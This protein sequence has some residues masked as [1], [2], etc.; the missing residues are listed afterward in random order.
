MPGKP[1]GVVAAP[2]DGGTTVSWT[3]PASDGGADITGYTVA[4][5]RGGG[6]CTTSGATTCTVTGLTNGV[7]YD[8]RVQ[9]T[10]SVGTGKGSK[11]VNVVA[12]Q[13]PDCSNFVNGANLQYC[14]LRLDNLSGLSLIGVN[15]SFSK[16][17]DTNLNGANLNDANLTSANATNANAQGV[18]L[19]DANLTNSFLIKVNM[20]D[21]DLSGATLS[22]ANMP[23]I[24]FT[25]ANL[26]GANMETATG[27]DSILWSD[28]TCPDGTNSDNDGGTCLNNLTPE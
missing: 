15:L 4:T 13:S 21:T 14:N 20:T 16:L 17:V 8:V 11:A 2:V 26:G 6:T 9:A 10:N 1:T 22:G 24:N 5:S 28:T 23:D 18:D 7:K 3:A 19:V 27:T 25:G 12:G